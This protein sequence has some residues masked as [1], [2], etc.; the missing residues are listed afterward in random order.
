M[1]G[2]NVPFRRLMLYLHI[3]HSFVSSDR[4]NWNILSPISRILQRVSSR[5][6]G[7]V[8]K[9]SVKYKNEDTRLTCHSFICSLPRPKVDTAFDNV[10]ELVGDNT[11]IS[12]ATTFA[13]PLISN[14]KSRT[15]VHNSFSRSYRVTFFNT[16]SRGYSFAKRKKKKSLVLHHLSQSCNNVVVDT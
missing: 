9:R 16:V 2:M 5:I 8:A 11:A 14:G 10:K 13:I 15:F 7:I 1:M 3:C 6:V 12:A 4:S